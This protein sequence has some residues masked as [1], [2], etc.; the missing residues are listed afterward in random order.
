MRALILNSGSSSI[1]YQLINMTTHKVLEHGLIEEISSNLHAEFEKIISHVKKIDFVAH[2]VVHGGDIF[3]EPVLIDTKVIEQI[4][5]LCKLAP[6]HNPANLD[7]IKTV[8]QLLADI[9][10]VAIFDTSFHQSMPKESYM[11][12]LPK[13]L[14]EQYHIRRYGFHGSSHSFLLKESAKILQKEIQELNIITLHLGNGESAAAI[15]NGKSYDT[16]MGFTPLEGLVMGSRSGDFDPAILLYLEDHG[17]NLKQ[18][19]D[20]VNKKSGLKGLCGSSDLREI[21]KREDEDAKLAL[22][23]MVHR[24]KKY[25]GAYI[26]LLGRV[27]AIVFSGGIGEHSA[28]IREMIAQGLDDAF[29][30]FLDKS[31]NAVMQRGII[32]QEQSRIKLLVIPTNEELEIALLANALLKKS[33]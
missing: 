31:V 5:S 12:A 1:K 20:L 22:A 2:R 16:S 25:I 3:H 13:E 7:G 28:I 8:K 17:F 9:P 18:L 23:V 19:S 24:I 29:G 11:Y 6:L 10:Q 32:S 15:K 30:I 21:I 26:A 4:A 33:R 14:Y 27:D